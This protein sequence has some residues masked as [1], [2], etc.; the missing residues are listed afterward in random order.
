MP[1]SEAV[2]Q[3]AGAVRHPAHTRGRAITSDD[4]IEQTDLPGLGHPIREGK[5]DAWVLLALFYL[6]KLFLPL[7][8]FGMLFATVWVAVANSTAEEE[9]LETLLGL[10]T[11]S[12]SVSALLSPF[13]FVAIAIV[14]RIA[15]AF[16]G[17]FAAFPIA[18]SAA[19]QR[20]RGGSRWRYYSD[21]MQIARAYRAVRRTWVARDAA[22]DRVGLSHRA[23]K[24]A[25]RTLSWSGIAFLILWIAVLLFG[26]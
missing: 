25:D 26:F 9:L 17:F 6:K 24:I 12:E 19:Q 2:G 14:L 13:A 10:D 11:F 8:F 22:A 18:L 7:I 4:P 21:R 5:V 1:E 16:V 15:V 20:P 3:Y 23:T